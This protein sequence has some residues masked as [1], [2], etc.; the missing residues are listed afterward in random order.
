MAQVDA[1][2][3]TGLPGLDHVLKGLIPGDNLAWQVDSILAL[4]PH[5]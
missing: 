5:K 3:S 2:L 4:F 1:Q